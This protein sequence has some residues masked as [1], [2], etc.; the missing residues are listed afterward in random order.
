MVRKKKY[1][2]LHFFFILYA[3]KSVNLGV[4]GVDETPNMLFLAYILFG[5]DSVYPVYLSLSAFWQGEL[6]CCFDPT[7]ISR[8]M[9]STVHSLQLL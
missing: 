3:F 6:F 5:F 9:P 4:Y 1:T 7:A 2:A 8:P